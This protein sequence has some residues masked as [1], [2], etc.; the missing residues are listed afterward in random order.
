MTSPTPEKSYASSSRSGLSRLLAKPIVRFGIVGVSN[1]VLGYSVFRLVLA[2]A[3]PFAARTAV[4]QCA[5][6]VAGMIWS[7]FLNKYWTF[8]S[9]GNS[10]KQAARFF[11]LQGTLMLVSALAMGGLVDVGGLNPSLAWVLIQ[12]VMISLNYVLSRN[13]A[14]RS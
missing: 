2:I 1:N 6:Y 10:V 11:A 13:W 4:A 3:P 12:S 7:F 9:E 5:C 14:F 8:T